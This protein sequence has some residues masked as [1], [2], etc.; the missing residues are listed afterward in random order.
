[1]FFPPH[2]HDEYS[3]KTSEN[4][5]TREGRKSMA[6]HRS[7]GGSLAAAASDLLNQLTVARG[8]SDAPGLAL[9]PLLEQRRGHHYGYG[10]DEETLEYVRAVVA[11]MRPQL[12]RS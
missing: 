1:M 2:R 10:F 11:A 9:L 4:T 6:R 3:S 5:L 7:H 8:S 12:P